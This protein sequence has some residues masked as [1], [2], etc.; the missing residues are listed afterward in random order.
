MQ[1]APLNR[2]YENYP[3]R[4]DAQVEQHLQAWQQGNTGFPMVDAAMRCLVETGYINF[5]MRALLVSFL[6]HYLHIHWQHATTH[7]AALFLDFEPG[8]HYPQ[9]QMQAGVIGTNTK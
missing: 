3:Y 6:C 9:I 4:S 2:A 7:L 5:R 1:N 8:I